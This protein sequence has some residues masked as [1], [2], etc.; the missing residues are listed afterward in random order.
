ML[1]RLLPVGATCPRAFYVPD[2]A[3]ELGER[4]ARFEVRAVGELYTASTP[5]TA[6]HPW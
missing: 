3:P 6:V 5:A 2:L 4:A 1:H